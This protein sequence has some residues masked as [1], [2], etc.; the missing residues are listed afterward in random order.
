MAKIT[1]PFP[2]PI[3]ETTRLLKLVFMIAAMEIIIGLILGAINQIRKGNPIGAL[4]EHGLGMILYV[5]GLY[6]SAMYFISIGMDFMK[7]LGNWTFYYDASR[8]S[9]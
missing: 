4:G 6:L 8:L 5:V 3:H 9:T 7:V 2:N 1:I